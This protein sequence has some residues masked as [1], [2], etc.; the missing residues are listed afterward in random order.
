MTAVNFSDPPV[1][2]VA[3]SVQFAPVGGLSSYRSGE[4]YERWRS[5]YPRVS[6]QAEVPPLPA[7]DAEDGGVVLHGR[8]WPDLVAPVV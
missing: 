6:Q 7:F 5:D 1:V 4:L 8:R 2:E 3:L